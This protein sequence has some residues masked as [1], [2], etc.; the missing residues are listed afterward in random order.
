M[1]L[2]NKKLDFLKDP[3]NI[4][5][6]VLLVTIILI[7]FS[8]F[9]QIGILTYDDLT[10]KLFA[11]NKEN[12][13]FKTAFSFAQ[14][15]GRFFFI[16]SGLL[17]FFPYLFDSVTY[18]RIIGF[19]PIILNITLFSLLIFQFFKSKKLSLIMAALFFAFMQ[20]SWEHNLLTAYPFVFTTSF[21]F[22]LIGLLLYKKYFYSPKK[23][24]K[25]ISAFCF[26]LSLLTYETFLVYFIFYF[27]IALNEALKTKF[28]LIDRAKMLLTNIGYH[29]FSIFVYF[30][31]YTLFQLRYPAGG[32]AGNMLGKLE[33]VKYM[34]TAFQLGISSF[35]GYIYLNKLYT[36]YFIEHSYSLFGDR[37]NILFILG[38]IQ[39]IWL[40]KALL[41]S[42]LI[43]LI[44]N[45]KEKI[46]NNKSYFFLILTSILL[47]FIPQLIIAL[48]DKYQFWVLGGSI[49]GFTTTYFSYFGSVFL[50][51]LIV[52]KAKEIFRPNI[53]KSL[54]LF[55]III[56]VS[57]LSI[58]IDYTNYHI[59]LSQKQMT[60]MWNVIKP[61]LKTPEFNEIPNNSYIY[62]PNLNT[63]FTYKGYWDNYIKIKTGKNIEFIIN[64][65]EFNKKYK[66]EPEKL[67]SKLYY[68]GYYQEEKDPNVFLTLSKIDSLV[69]EGELFGFFS[70]NVNLYTYSK[71]RKYLLNFQT[72]VND[73]EPSAFIDDQKIFSNSFGFSYL[74]N[75]NFPGDSLLKT[76]IKAPNIN[77][78]SVLISYFTSLDSTYLK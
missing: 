17:L 15:Q 67:T 75:K 71:Y 18:T 31:V 73:N 54:I 23:F 62:S 19:L 78:Q 43:W 74:V 20:N 34:Q 77:I 70:N 38:N 14:G 10:N 60:L 11:I 47:V 26:F 37:R 3:L 69:K 52:Y 39:L 6:T 28:H 33:P 36:N 57:I 41:L 2:F 66:D 72:K 76:V 27:F 5:I 35:P 40:I 46:I 22:T 55:F 32:Y 51:S 4:V 21:N 45:F 13:L 49:I 12:N 56:T 16:Y 68:L 59:N 7:V 61:L 53:L 8:S 64:K 44:S 42:L 63:F 24:W 9:S 58:I 48:T 1:T 65:E 29:L 50:L 25:I 30:S